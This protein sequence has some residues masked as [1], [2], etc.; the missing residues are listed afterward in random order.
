MIRV[1]CLQLTEVGRGG[2]RICVEPTAMPTFSSHVV[3]SRRMRSPEKRIIK[4]RPLEWVL[5]VRINTYR[6]EHPRE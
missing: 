6:K 5:I 1:G 3:R 4:E 2:S